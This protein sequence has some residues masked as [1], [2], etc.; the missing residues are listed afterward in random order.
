MM[1]IRSDDCDLP[2][3]VPHFYLFFRF[4]V[5]RFRKCRQSRDPSRYFCDRLQRPTENRE[6][7]NTLLTGL[8]FFAHRVTLVTSLPSLA[9]VQPL[10]S[11]RIRFPWQRQFREVRVTRWSSGQFDLLTPRRPRLNR[12]GGLGSNYHQAALKCPRPDEGE[13]SRTAEGGGGWRKCQRVWHRCR[14]QSQI[15][16]SS[17]TV[18]DV[19][20]TSQ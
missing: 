12:R 2:D 17:P 8:D 6:I 7:S 14:Q 5:L 19:H 11:D 4:F 1:L 3:N 10:I 18:S 13:G 16:D 20:L 9:A 15:E